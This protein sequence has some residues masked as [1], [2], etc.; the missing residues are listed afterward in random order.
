M[1]NHSEVVVMRLP[2]CDIDSGHGA[3]AYDAKTKQGPWGYLCEDCYADHGIGL[4]LGKGQ[5]LVLRAEGEPGDRIQQFL[6]N[7]ATDLA[8]LRELDG[9]S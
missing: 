1:N 9:R 7:A 5:R 4:G 8:E 2:D 3:A 6:D